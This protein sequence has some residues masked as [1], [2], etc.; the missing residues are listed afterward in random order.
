MRVRGRVDDRLVEV[1]RLGPGG[2]DLVLGRRGE[3]HAL[4]LH[5]L[6]ASAS[7]SAASPRDRARRSARPSAIIGN[8]WPGSPKAPRQDPSRRGTSASARAS[9]GGELGEHPQLLE[10]LVAP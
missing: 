2:E 7:T 8:A 6:A 4:G 5:V 3:G 1:E 10:A 9:S